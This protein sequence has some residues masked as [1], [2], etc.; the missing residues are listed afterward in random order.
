MLPSH[1]DAKFWL[2]DAL[3]N[4]GE[5][6]KLLVPCRC[7]GCCTGALC[8]VRLG[9]CWFRSPVGAVPREWGVLPEEWMPRRSRTR[10]HQVRAVHLECWLALS[11]S[12]P[13]GPRHEFGCRHPEAPID[14]VAAG[15]LR[16]HDIVLLPQIPDDLLDRS[17][18]G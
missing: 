4:H 16:N 8:V 9:V 13:V 18:R 1:L 11:A 5:E 17:S 6:L 2:G 14:H 7:C 3:P 12:H 15:L 10:R